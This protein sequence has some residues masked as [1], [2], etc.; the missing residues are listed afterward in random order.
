M[1]PIF[2]TLDAQSQVWY[3]SS[4]YGRVAAEKLAAIL[5]EKAVNHG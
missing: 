1:K 4:R 5:N 3:F 2:E